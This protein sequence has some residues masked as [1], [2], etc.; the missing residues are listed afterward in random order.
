MRVGQLKR[1]KINQLNTASQKLSL[2][3]STLSI[4]T[5][6]VFP[7]PSLLLSP[8]LPI[9]LHPFPI[10][11]LL[12][13]GSLPPMTQVC[14]AWKNAQVSSPSLGPLSTVLLPL[15]GEDSSS[16]QLHLRHVL[17]PSIESCEYRNQEYGSH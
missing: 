3:H 5:R 14:E 9:H 10:L 12:T 7:L 4:L 6:L 8:P 1:S 17:C 13:S 11:P 2:F 16:G 15:S